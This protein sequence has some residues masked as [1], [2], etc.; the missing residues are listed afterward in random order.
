MAVF[1][2]A[3]V[4]NGL[5]REMLSQ[6]LNFYATMKADPRF[7]EIAARS[8]ESLKRPGGLTAW[9]FSMCLVMVIFFAMGGALAGAFLRRRER[10]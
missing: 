2:S 4:Y 8:V 10:K 1:F 5:L 7:Q 3:A 9:L 6:T